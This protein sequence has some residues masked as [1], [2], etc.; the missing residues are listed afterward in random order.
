[1]AVS[2]KCWVFIQEVMEETVHAKLCKGGY[3]TAEESEGDSLVLSYAYESCR[4]GVRNRQYD[5]IN[6]KDRRKLGLPVN[7]WGLFKDVKGL[8][9]NM[10]LLEKKSSGAKRSIDVVGYVCQR[11]MKRINR[12]DVSLMSLF[13]A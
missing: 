1:M 8:V 13:L 11:Q 6:I 5:W 3:L 12:L 9:S 7:E 10:E 4:T 2:V